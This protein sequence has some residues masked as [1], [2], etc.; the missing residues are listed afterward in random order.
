MLESH[1]FEVHSHLVQ[2]DIVAS[3]ITWRGRMAID[4][5]QLCAGTELVAHISQHTTVRDGRIWRTESC[6]CYEP[7]GTEP[8]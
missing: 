4:A 7:F 8:G 5:G 2:E 3:R 1:R 6:D